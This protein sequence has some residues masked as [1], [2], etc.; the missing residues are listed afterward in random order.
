MRH[1]DYMESGN[2]AVKVGVPTLVYFLMVLFLRKN[3][4]MQL[5]ITSTV[6]TMAVT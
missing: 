5:S 3:A 6:H 4:N 2:W 1:T